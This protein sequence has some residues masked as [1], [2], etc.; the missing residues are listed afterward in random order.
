MSVSSSTS[1]SLSDISFSLLHNWLSKH[2]TYNLP[3][4]EKCHMY[5]RGL[6]CGSSG[7]EHQLFKTCNNE[8]HQS[9]QNKLHFLKGRRKKRYT[10]APAKIIC[11]VGASPAWLS[12]VSAWF[13]AWPVMDAYIKSLQWSLLLATFS[14]SHMKE[15][16]CVRGHPKQNKGL[17]KGHFPGH[18]KKNLEHGH[19]TCS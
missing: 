13:K 2:L 16:M 9:Y 17:A 5:I 15:G 19:D 3:R 7:R 11:R 4:E 12:G 10:K 14:L 8:E 18:L 1:D 6:S